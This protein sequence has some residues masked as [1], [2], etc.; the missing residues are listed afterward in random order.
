MQFRLSAHADQEL[1]RRRIPRT[2]LDQVLETP[3]QIVEEQQGRKAYQSV[4]DFGGGRMF[5]LRAIVRDDIEPGIVVT[6]Y[7]TSRIAKYW[8]AI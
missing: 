5:L 3:Q 1:I 6:V 7:R 2:L 8:R 4:L